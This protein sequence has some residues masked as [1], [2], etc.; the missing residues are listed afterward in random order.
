MAIV[1]TPGRL[2]LAALRRLRDAGGEALTLD[3][4]CRPAVERGAATVREVLATGRAVYGVNTGF[5]KLAQTRI[6]DDKLRGLQ[7]SLVL[8]HSAGVGPLLGAAT[9]RLVVALKAAG[10]RACAPQ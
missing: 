6:A 2:T 9:V 1:L 8:S 5:G 7:E 3:P 10:G 4:A